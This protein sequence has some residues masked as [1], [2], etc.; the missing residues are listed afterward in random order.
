MKKKVKP[1]AASGF[2][3]SRPRAAA[4]QDSA[5]TNIASTPRT[6]SQRSGSVVGR[7]PGTTATPITTAE[8]SRLRS[9]LSATCPVS[10]ADRA[11]AMVRN[12]SMMPSAK[13]V[14]SATAVVEAPKPAHSKMI[15]G[16]T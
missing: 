8:V 12:R 2:R 5:K 15:P 11:M 13:S 7:K 9:T 3:A 14:D 10:T 16:T 6:P 4:S 1:L